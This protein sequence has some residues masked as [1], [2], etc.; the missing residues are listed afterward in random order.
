MLKYSSVTGSVY[1]GIVMQL[2]EMGFERE[3]CVKALRAA[4][5]NPD[6]AVEYL[7]NVSTLSPLW[8]KKVIEKKRKQLS[9]VHTKNRESQQLSP[10]QLASPQALQPRHR[11]SLKLSNSTSLLKPRRRLRPMARVNWKEV[12]SFFFLFF[13]FFPLC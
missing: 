8:K 10:S 5:N 1:E 6:R 12:C 2:M 9:I 4:F 3:Q 7:F 11:L 13:L